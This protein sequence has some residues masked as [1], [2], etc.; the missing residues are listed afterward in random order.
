MFHDEYYYSELINILNLI[1]LG[2]FQKELKE[3]TSLNKI[4]YFEICHSLKYMFLPKGESLF[5]V[6]QESDKIYYLMYGS[7]IATSPEIEPVPVEKVQSQH[8]NPHITT[9]TFVTE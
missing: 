2:K 1:D 6:D 7:L 5:R 8:L 4:D 3:K 9:S